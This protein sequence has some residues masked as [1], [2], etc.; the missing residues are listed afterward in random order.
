MI[1]IVMGVS[2][3]GKSTIGEMLASAL[4]WGFCDADS[5]HSPANLQKMSQGIPLKDGDRIPWLAAM[6]KAIA[7]WLQEERNMV[8]ACSALKSSY[9]Q[10]LDCD[11][12]QMR[13]VY[14]Q[15]NFDLIQQRLAMRQHHFMNPQLLQSQFDTLEEPESAIYIDISQPP[16]AIV[17]QIIQTLGISN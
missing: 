15:G 6:Q 12:E 4:N 7:L 3:S 5:F 10:M 2:G 9:R 14:L 17:R 11:P 1:V 16:A 8:L 13:F